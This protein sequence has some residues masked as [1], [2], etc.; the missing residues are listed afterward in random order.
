VISYLAG[1]V[2]I[3]SHLSI[4]DTSSAAFA[5][6]QSALWVSHPKQA[7]LIAFNDSSAFSLDMFL[8]VYFHVGIFLTGQ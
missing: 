2:C 3:V 6:E 1:C 7:L 8:S 4:S 5:I